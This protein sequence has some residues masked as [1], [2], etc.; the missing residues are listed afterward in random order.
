ME[1]ALL[2]VIEAARRRRAR[3]ALRWRRLAGGR[4]TAVKVAVRAAAG[5]NS[6]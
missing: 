2:N 1:R 3:L 5:D 4:A 6:A